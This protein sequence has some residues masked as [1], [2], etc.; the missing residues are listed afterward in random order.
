TARLKLVPENVESVDAAATILL[1]ISLRGIRAG[2]VRFG[3]SVSIFGLG[4]IGQYAVHLAKLSGAYPV[5]A[6]DPVARR[7][8]VA[9]RT[10][11]DLA[12][13]P[14]SPDLAERI[15]AATDN[16]GTRISIDATGTPSVIAS[17][18]D[19]TAPFGT[20]VVLGGVHGT[21]PM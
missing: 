2:K 12:L 20:L 15:G 19:H 16:E 6:V 13:D 8:E 1:G 9:L 21:V 7:R 3:D 14:R 18:A 4:V 17:L 11:A 5:I 10:G